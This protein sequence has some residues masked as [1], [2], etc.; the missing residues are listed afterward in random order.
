MRLWLLQI[1][2]VAIHNELVLW[3]GLL[4]MEINESVW[5]MNSD[6]DFTI[7]SLVVGGCCYLKCVVC[8]HWEGSD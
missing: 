6:E 8:F 5:V 2:G 3:C 4:V 1:D 7:L